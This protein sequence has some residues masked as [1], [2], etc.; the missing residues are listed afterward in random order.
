MGVSAQDLLMAGR[1]AVRS[2]SDPSRCRRLSHLAS[3][4]ALTRVLPGVFVAPTAVD[5]PA[6]LA[7][8]AL[9]SCPAGIVA[10]PAAAALTFWPE[11]SVPTIEVATRFVGRQF[12]RSTFRSEPSRQ[13]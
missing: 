13:T 6:V 5:D 3:T 8:A 11:L 4:G 9:L 12:H 2:S 1:G 7:R 10:G